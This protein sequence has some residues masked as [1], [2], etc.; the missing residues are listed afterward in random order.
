VNRRQVQ[1][2][3]CYGRLQLIE[4]LRRQLVALDDDGAQPVGVDGTRREARRFQYDLDFLTFDG[5][6]GIEEANG[7]SPADNFLEFHEA[8]VLGLGARLVLMPI[9]RAAHY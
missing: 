5:S 2:Q 8:S 9:V 1:R 7:A 3:R 6:F 4:L